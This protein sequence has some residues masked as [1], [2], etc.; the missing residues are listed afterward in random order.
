VFIFAAMAVVGS[1]MHQGR[2]YGL[3]VTVVGGGG[4]LLLYAFCA[5]VF[6]I[7]EFR[8]LLRSVGGRFGR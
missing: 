7:E 5:R 4:A 6:G 8:A 2:I 3:V 1:L